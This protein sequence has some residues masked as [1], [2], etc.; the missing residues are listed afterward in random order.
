MFALT[1][2]IIKTFGVIG[3]VESSLRFSIMLWRAST[4]IANAVRRRI[5]SAAATLVAFMLVSLPI[6]C[7]AAC[8]WAPGWL[9]GAQATR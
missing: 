4:E 5:N 1:M 9:M 8:S 2:P 6:R 3:P 7:E